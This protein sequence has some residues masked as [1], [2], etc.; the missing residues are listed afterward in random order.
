METNTRSSRPIY[1]NGHLCEENTVLDPS[2]LKTLC[3]KDVTDA[4]ARIVEPDDL[5]TCEDCARRLLSR[6]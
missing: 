5:I 2:V 4:A 6:R 1:W 3:S